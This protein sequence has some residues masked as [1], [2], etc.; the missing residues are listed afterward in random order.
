VSYKPAEFQRD[1]RYREIDITAEKDG[2]KLKVYARKGYFA[3]AAQR[4]SGDN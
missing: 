4:A 2:H 1:G 3:G